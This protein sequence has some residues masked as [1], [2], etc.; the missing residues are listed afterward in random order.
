MVHFQTLLNQLLFISRLQI[1]VQVL[2]LLL[3]QHTQA[4]T[5]CTTTFVKLQLLFFRAVHSTIL[6]F[7]L[8]YATITG[9]NNLNIGNHRKFTWILQV[10]TPGQQISFLRLP[11]TYP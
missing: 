6:L 11:A 4:F 8:M 2:D 10:V 7:Y 9:P 1:K 3:S 5:Q